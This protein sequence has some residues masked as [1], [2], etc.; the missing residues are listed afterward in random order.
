MNPP[1]FCAA[2]VSA[3]FFL[4]F[5]SPSIRCAN[6]CARVIAVEEPALLCEAVDEAVIIGLDIECITISGDLF[7]APEFKDMVGLA[8][9]SAGCTIPGRSEMGIFRTWAEARKAFS[10]G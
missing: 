6:S 5:S 7:N 1:L 3:F 2:S 10:G 8:T 9:G 4:S